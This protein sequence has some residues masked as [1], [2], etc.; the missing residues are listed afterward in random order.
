MTATTA[1]VDRALA[2]SFPASDSPPWTFGVADLQPPSDR[3][4][5]SDVVVLSRSEVSTWWRAAARN[6]AAWLM[7]CGVVLLVPVAIIALPVAL[8]VRALSTIRDAGRVW[9]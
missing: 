9:K 5:V 1:A 7:A 8:T 4:E 2:Q 6:V 3:V